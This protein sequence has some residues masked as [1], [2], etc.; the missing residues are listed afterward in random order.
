MAV[1]AV[2]QR[3]NRSLEYRGEIAKTATG[4]YQIKHNEKSPAVMKQLGLS[5]GVQ[6][7]RQ[8]TH[9]QV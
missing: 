4:R 7:V 3:V 5:S 1:S 6:G 8:S 9:Q 2:H